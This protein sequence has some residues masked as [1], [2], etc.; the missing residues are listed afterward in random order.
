[1]L[2]ATAAAAVLAVAGGVTG[3]QLTSSGGGTVPAPTV[4][5]SAY[6]VVYE[7]TA[8]NTPTL[9]DVREVKRPFDG[10]AVMLTADGTLSSGTLTTGDGGYLYV[11]AAEKGWARVQGGLHRAAGDQN[12]APA[13]AFGAA[14]GLVQVRGHGRVL[15]RACT[16]ARTGG[17]AGSPL[18][19]PTTANHADMCV[20]DATGLVLEERWTLDGALVRTRRAVE[21]DLSPRFDASTFTAEPKGPDLLGALASSQGVTAVVE[22]PDS[23]AAEQ[24]ASFD[25]PAGYHRAN[26]QAETTTTP[27]GPVGVVVANFVDDAGH[28]L[29]FRQGSPGGGDSAVPVTLPGGTRARMVVDL[30]ASRLQWTLANGTHVELEGADPGSL[31]RWAGRVHVQ[32]K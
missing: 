20:D 24:H 2:V 6:R 11:N 18:A 30:T 32:G 3:W 21:L 19:R 9:R 13:L 27:A 7:Q 8:P 22:L 5:L 10:R 31:I 16:W 17:P 12:A 29:E 4:T 15:G 28:L 25:P 26:L 1:M 23:A 14:H